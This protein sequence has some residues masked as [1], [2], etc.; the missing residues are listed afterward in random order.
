MKPVLEVGT[1]P[2]VAAA[3]AQ[4]PKEVRVLCVT[5]GH[6]CAVG[7]DHVCGEQTVAGHPIRA[8]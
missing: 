4:D 8:A 7:R 5:G 3:T 2:E 1:E 6:E